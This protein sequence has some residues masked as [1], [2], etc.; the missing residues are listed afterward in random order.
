MVNTLRITSIVVVLIAGVLVVLVIGPKSLGPKLLAKFAMGSDEE[1]ARIL[2]A[3][4][5]VD[6]FRENQGSRN[7]D[8]Q[9]TTSP[10]VKQAEAFAGILTPNESAVISGK[11][12]IRPGQ[13]R[14]PV[15]TPAPPSAKFN[16][17][18]TA[19]AAS[20]PDGS[21]AYIRLADDTVQ[22]V[23][24]GDEVGHLVVKEIKDRSIVYWDGHSDVEMAVEAAPET[25]SLLETLG[26][27]AVPAK[28]EKAP[29]RPG[30]DRITGPPTPRPWAPSRA[31]ARPNTT[32]NAQERD[33]LE[34]LANRIKAAKAAGAAGTPEERAAAIEKL[35]S[36]YKSSRISDEE[37]EDVEDR[38]RELNAS[39]KMSPD[40]KRT[41]L[42]RK[43]NIP[44]SP[45]R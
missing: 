4:G 31:T 14:P 36:E 17:V 24:K 35:V 10:L 39:Q 18:G 21:F 34:E 42:R 37:A 26:A 23:R 12:T 2:D 15:V 27:A 8:R 16:L 22:W 38:G 1:V 9:E 3:P 5:V 32:I 41:N 33:K 20:D 7:Q 29:V 25:A 44:R 28:V 40:Q 13:R 6:W 30:G 45:S 11:T 43:L 19:Y